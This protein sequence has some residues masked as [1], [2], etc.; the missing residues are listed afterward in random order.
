MKN[1]VLL[2]IIASLFCYTLLF[3][4]SSCSRP[5]P[6]YPRHIKGFLPVN[7]Q[8]LTYECGEK[9]VTFNTASPVFTDGYKVKFGEKCACSASGSI[10]LESENKDQILLEN[11]FTTLPGEELQDHYSLYIS[12][13]IGNDYFQ[14]LYSNP[15]PASGEITFDNSGLEKLEN[16]TSTLGET[17]PAVFRL[18][19]EDIQTVIYLSDDLG[20]VQIELENG[21]IWTLR[22]GSVQ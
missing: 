4:T 20:L 13:Q 5:C 6:A 18:K 10:L 8:V 12:F 21:N 7:T 3:L 16:W 15:I 17:F 22:K 11:Q 2:I 9:S 1:K 19:N 14:K